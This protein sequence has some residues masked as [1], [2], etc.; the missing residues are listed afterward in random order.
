MIGWA[1]SHFAGI[2]PLVT[3]RSACAIAGGSPAAAKT[4]RAIPLAR[5]FIGG[6]ERDRRGISRKP[7]GPAPRFA[8]P[9]FAR[10]GRESTKSGRNRRVGQHRPP[11]SRSLRAFA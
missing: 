2:P 8:P 6:A 11:L 7:W 9:P 5:L 1:L 10:N 3:R 4:R